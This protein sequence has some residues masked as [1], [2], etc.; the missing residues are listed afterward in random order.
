[1]SEAF[2]RVRR[3]RGPKGPRITTSEKVQQIQEDLISARLSATQGSLLHNA[4]NGAASE[5]VNITYEDYI[6]YLDIFKQRLY[7]VWPVLDCDDL[8]QRLSDDPSDHETYA[9]A[10]SLCSAVIAQLRLPEHETEPSSRSITSW[11]FSQEAQKLRQLFEYRETFSIASLLTSFFLHIYYANAEKLR[12]AGF[13]L[14]EAIGCSFG[15][16]MHESESYVPTWERENQLKIR[17]F[18]VLF[19]SERTYCIQNGMPM[20]LQTIEYLPET[21]E[22]DSQERKVLSAFVN[23]TQLFVHLDS[24]FAKSLQGDTSKSCSSCPGYHREEMSAIQQKL[25]GAEGEGNDL[26]ESQQVDI[27]VTRQWIRTLLWQYTISHFA[28]SCNSTDLAFSSLLPA[29]IAKETLSNFNKFSPSSIKTHGYGIEIKLFRLA[30]T[31]L[32]VLVCVPASSSGHTM[33]FGA[34]DA[35][36]ALEHLLLMVGGTASPFLHGLRERMAKSEIPV[37]WA[38]W[39]EPPE[40]ESDSDSA[41]TVSTSSF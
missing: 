4:V 37:P 25:C 16:R 38:R 15:L 1:M 10:A 31:L 22:D 39:L 30:D 14:R 27:M 34:R 6:R 11:H 19:I 35:L 20:M 33:L 23:L 32:D 3:K 17:I 28:V 7:S 8:I 9:L 36:H 12:S 29:E 40:S 21:T 13:F 18:W 26:R 2:A 41:E 24:G 5:N